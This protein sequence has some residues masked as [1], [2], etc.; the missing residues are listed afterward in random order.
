MADAANKVNEQFSKLIPITREAAKHYKSAEL[1]HI[2]FKLLKNFCFRDIGARIKDEC[3]SNVIPTLYDYAK[4]LAEKSE[5]L[6]HIKLSCAG[7][8][9]SA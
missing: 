3:C 5:F 7:N 6:R 1:Q 8:I 2:H 4:V 9:K